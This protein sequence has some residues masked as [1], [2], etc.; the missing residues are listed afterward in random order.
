MY[1]LSLTPTLLGSFGP[2]Y[3]LLSYNILYRVY[4][5]P[6]GFGSGRKGGPVGHGGISVRP[7]FLLRGWKGLK[8]LQRVFMV[9]WASGGLR[10][11]QKGRWVSRKTHETYLR[12]PAPSNQK[13]Q[14]LAPPSCSLLDPP[15]RLFLLSKS[16]CFLFILVIKF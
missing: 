2:S 8:E 3:P 15:L 13:I 12:V 9:R 14:Q 6:R 4:I 1:T 10:R 11:P 7:S 5:F 16:G